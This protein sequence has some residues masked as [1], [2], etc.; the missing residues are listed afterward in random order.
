VDPRESGG[1][2]SETSRI[3]EV[4]EI[5]RQLAALLEDPQ[6]GLSSWLTLYGEKMQAL[7]AFWN[8]GPQ[9]PPLLS[10]IRSAK[11]EQVIHVQFTRGQG[12]EPSPVRVVDAWFTMDGVLIAERD[13]CAGTIPEGM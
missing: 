2:V 1:D 12:I 13:P 4:R 8:S 7:S 11:V 10:A 3:D 5:V 6:V 9:V